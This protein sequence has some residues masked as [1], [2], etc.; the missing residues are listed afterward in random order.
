M[1]EQDLPDDHVYWP[2]MMLR[3][4]EPQRFNRDVLV[5]VHS[6]PHLVKYVW[7]SAE[8]RAMLEKNLRQAKQEKQATTTGENKGMVF[9]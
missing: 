6:I 3:C 5:G 1:S 2:P 7:M 9:D 8:E 4:L